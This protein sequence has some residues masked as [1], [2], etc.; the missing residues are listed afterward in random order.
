MRRIHRW[1]VNSPHKGQWRRAFMFSLIC[2]WITGW[3]NNSEAG[4]L[5]RHCGHYDVTVMWLVC[6]YNSNTLSKYSEKIKLNGLNYARYRPVVQEHFKIVSCTE[7]CFLQIIRRLLIILNSHYL[8]AL[9]YQL[10][11][12][13]NHTRNEISI[14]TDFVTNHEKDINNTRI[15]GYD[16]GTFLVT[17][18]CFICNHHKALTRIRFNGL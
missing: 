17:T 6:L 11:T 10:H 18:Y 2:A 3:I 13:I 1:P 7:K 12:D 9:E 15:S 5:R 8:R 14:Y 16:T 4:V